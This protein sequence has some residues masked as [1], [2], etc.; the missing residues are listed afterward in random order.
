MSVA[1]LTQNRRLSIAPM[2]DWSDRH[3]RYLCRLMSKNVL[4][5]SEMVVTHALLHGDPERF[6]RYNIE[7][8]PVALQLGG[9]N[10]AELAQCARMAE[11]YGYDEVNLN[12]G[13]PSDRVQ[14]GRFGACLMG[15]AMLVADCVSAMRAAVKIPVTVKTRIGIDHHDSWEFFRGFIATVASA[16]CDTFTIHARK[17]WLQGLSPKQNREKP[18]LHYGFAYRLKQEMPHLNV[19]LNGG[20]K[21]LDAVSAILA[22]ASTQGLT[23]DQ[24]G[25]VGE[26]SHVAPVALDGVMVG[27]AAYETPWILAEA[28]ERIF[29]TARACPAT[30]R[31]LL[32]AFIPYLEAQVA[33][34]VPAHIV[35]RHL[36][37]FFSGR[38]GA[39]R[40]RQLMGEG[41]TRPGQGVD[42]LRQALDCVG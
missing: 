15:E 13:C 18:P 40:F 8:H 25:P 22:G 3:M 28:D 32:E 10:P 31:E 26:L 4:L 20:V 37:G 42:L 5:Y 1:N 34:G 11:D 39:R 35:T 19:S 16:G 14:S 33:L 7:E 29:G 30:E 38:P 12:C 17:A 24:G 41:A 27:R 21:A 6:L 23:A 2:L 9:S 36:M